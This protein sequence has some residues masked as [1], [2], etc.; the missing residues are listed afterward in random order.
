MSG[1]PAIGNKG[2]AMSKESGLNLVPFEGPPT[3]TS[4]F[5]PPV[6]E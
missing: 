1:F 5:T 4:A 3:N 2:F 6:L